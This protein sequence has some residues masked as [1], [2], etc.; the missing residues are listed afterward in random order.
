MISLNFPQPSET[1]FSDSYYNS[2]VKL[3]PYHTHFIFVHDKEVGSSTA[4][5]AEQV[6]ATN[7]LR[8]LF[9]KEMAVCKCAPEHV[10]TRY[11]YVVP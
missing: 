3:D 11:H 7:D 2:D 9:E 6:K 10:L 4:S 1:A 8:L 5:F